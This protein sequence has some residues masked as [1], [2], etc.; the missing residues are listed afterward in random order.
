M[1]ILWSSNKWRCF[2]FYNSS[3]NKKDAATLAVVP[4]VYHL[5]TLP[6]FKII[7][8]IYLPACQTTCHNIQK[9][10]SYSAPLCVWS[11]HLLSWWNL[12]QERVS[13][14]LLSVVLYINARADYVTVYA[15]VLLKDTNKVRADI[16][17]CYL[18]ACMFNMASHCLLVIS[19]SAYQI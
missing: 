12:G 13:Y 18:S 17:G 4:P 7:L 11:N 19:L 16:F 2:V 5:L 15:L 14:K 10:S 9:S 6:T 1:I 3:V 8:T